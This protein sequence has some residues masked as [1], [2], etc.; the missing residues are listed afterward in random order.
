[1]AEYNLQYNNLKK[2]LVTLKLIIDSDMSLDD[3]TKSIF[4]KQINSA[5]IEL[6]ERYSDGKTL[7][8][9]EDTVD[10]IIIK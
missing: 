3:A 6:D 5:L 1:M 4:K 2:R 7:N 8:S 10:K 9:I